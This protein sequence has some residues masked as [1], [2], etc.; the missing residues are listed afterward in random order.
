MLKVVMELHKVKFSRLPGETFKY[1]SSTLPGNLLQSWKINE[2][3]N[4]VFLPFPNPCPLQH[5]NVYEPTANISLAKE[6]R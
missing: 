4:L 6:W 1:G 3:F 5:V 2:M